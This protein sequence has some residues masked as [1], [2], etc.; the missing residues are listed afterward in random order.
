MTRLT[1]PDVSY[2][3]GLDLGQAQDPTALAVLEKVR[4]A[5]HP[6]EGSPGSPSGRPHWPGSTRKGGRP[7]RVI[8]TTA[9]AARRNAEAER[10][11]Q[12][13]RYACGHLERFR[14]GTSYPAVVARVGELLR[15]PPFAGRTALV[16]D[17][18]GVGRAVTDMLRQAGLSPVVITITGGDSVTFEGGAWRVPK[19]D[20]VG[21]TQVLL[22]SGRLKVA[23]SLQ[24]APTL[25]SELL[26]F[27]VKISELTA[28][29]SYGA[30]REGSHD[31]LVLALAC[32]AWYA[33][34][35][36]PPP[37]RARPFS[38]TVDVFGIEDAW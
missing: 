3:M 35:W 32:A 20:L 22:Q 25:V 37:V 10:R 30:W 15:T 8:I 38:G 17:G 29:D 4:A 1:E 31:D 28:H 5:P 36:R 13:A 27:R 24:L 12:T 9:E 14:L 7:Q 23:E 2:F 26:T 33:E 19:R 11:E 6:A 34:R 18:T 21:V 16:V